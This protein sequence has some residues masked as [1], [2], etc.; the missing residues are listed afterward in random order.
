[1]FKLLFKIID[2]FSNRKF[3]HYCGEIISDVKYHKNYVCKNCGL[4]ANDVVDKIVFDFGYGY[5]KIHSPYIKVFD[6]IDLLKKRI[7]YSEIYLDIG[8]NSIENIT[9]IIIVILNNKSEKELNKVK[10]FLK[11]ENHGLLFN[12][13][14]IIDKNNYFS[15]DEAIIDIGCHIREYRS[16][17]IFHFENSLNLKKR[18]NNLTE[19]YIN[20]DSIYHNVIQKLIIFIN[21]NYNF[22]AQDDL[23]YYLHGSMDELVYL[24][25][26]LNMNKIYLYDNITDYYYIDKIIF[27]IGCDIQND[28]SNL[29]FKFNDVFDLT[30]KIIEIDEIQINTSPS[31]HQVIEKLITYLMEKYLSDE[32]SS[33]K[34]IIE[35]SLDELPMNLKNSLANNFII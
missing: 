16:A 22:L 6:S 14:N 12:I 10:L 13:N 19:I 20:T 1:M 30:K 11:G 35:G 21:E 23:E 15:I 8:K 3:C 34:L 2:F 9:N 33:M 24:M 5:N 31:Y 27:N 32:I 29:V 17:L 7:K 18:I 28:P 25:N 4:N 26:N